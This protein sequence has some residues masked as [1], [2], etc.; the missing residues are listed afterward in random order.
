MF[1]TIG[2]DLD[3]E[4]NK[5]RAQSLLL[6]LVGLGAVVGFVVGVTAYTAAELVADTT[7]DTEMVPLVLADPEVELDGPNLPPPPPPSAAKAEVEPEDDVEPEPEPDPDSAPVELKEPVE[8]PMR[9]AA[10]PAGMD[11]G[12]D[13]GDPNGE[14]GGIPGGV[15]GGTGDRPGDGGEPRTFH[16]REL[17]TRRRVQPVYPKGAQTLNLGEQRCKA[18]VRISAEGVPTDIV[19][20]DC[21]SVFHGPTREALLQWRWYPPR[22]GKRKV[23]AQTVI[24]ITYTFR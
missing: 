23:E 20:E 4:A 14:P 18:R 11:G 21:P 2:R 10:R 17:E 24:A 13:G 8:A 16:H 15:D 12:V 19:V 1:D 6:S 22:D 9:S 7:Q 5:R 3:E